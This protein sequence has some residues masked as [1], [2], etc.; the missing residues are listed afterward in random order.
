MRMVR[1]APV[2]T[3]IL[4]SGCGGILTVPMVQRLD[5]EAQQQVDG[6]WSNL[7]TPPNRLDR[8]LLLDALMANQLHESGVDEL[9]MVSKKRVGDGL[10]VMEVDFERERPEADGF[11]FTY[12]SSP[13]LEIRRE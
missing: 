6:I 1:W 4:L 8:T 7:L 12:V 11:T 2:L 9:R 5:P 3:L 10:A 13:G